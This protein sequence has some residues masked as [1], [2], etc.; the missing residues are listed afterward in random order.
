[1]MNPRLLA[2]VVC[3]AL[4]ACANPFRQQVTA[5]T[6]V[7]PVVLPQVITA[8]GYGAPPAGKELSAA[9]KRLLAMRA[10]KLDA[11]RGLMETIQG[12]RISSQST[13][14]MLTLQ[15]DGLRA[16]V[17]GYLRGARV[18]S[19]RELADGAFETTLE[20]TLAPAFLQAL[21]GGDPSALPPPVAVPPP[22]AAGAEVQVAPLQAAPDSAVAAAA[23]AAPQPT[24]A[25]SKRAA[26]NFYYAE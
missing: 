7:P 13:V 17:E 20:L 3:L 16:F 22:A 5:D 19:S 2:L 11:Y 23:A 21:A 6:P 24:P 25:L 26:A 1:M 10:S 14:A 4:A 8:V 9:Q 12:V 18:V 15:N